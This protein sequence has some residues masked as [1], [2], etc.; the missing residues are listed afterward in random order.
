MV[1]F[2]RMTQTKCKKTEYMT[3][4]T[5]FFENGEKLLGI[6][7]SFE[8]VPPKVLLNKIPGKSN[9]TRTIAG[10]AIFKVHQPLLIV[11]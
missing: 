7:T 4:F 11:I 9:K 3:I 6:T 5:I 8:I 10:N 1:I 2:D